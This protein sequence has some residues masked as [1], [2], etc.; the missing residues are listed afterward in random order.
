MDTDLVGRKN[1]S[2]VKDIIVVEADPRAAEIMALAHH[3][4]FG[5]V[6]EM[7]PDMLSM[8]RLAANF[9]RSRAYACER[10][11]FTEF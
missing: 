10:E 3:T 8:L 4:I 7:S 1:V 5:Q 2:V 9:S 6:W 11:S